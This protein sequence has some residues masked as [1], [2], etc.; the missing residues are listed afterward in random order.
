[1]RVRVGS[2]P[3]KDLL[4]RA[5]LYRIVTDFVAAP[6]SIDARASAYGP[7]VDLAVRLTRK[8]W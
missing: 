4:A 5:L 1:M 8:R 6:D 2:A 3:P 7:A